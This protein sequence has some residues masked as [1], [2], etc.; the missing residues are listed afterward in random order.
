MTQAELLRHLVDALEALGA[1]Y[2]IGG[3]GERVTLKIVAKHADHWNCWG[4][5]RVLGR[6]GKIL[7]EH[8]A[9]L[10]RD[11]KSFKRSANMALLI[12]DNK[13]SGVFL[14][15]LRDEASRVI[16]GGEKQPA[17]SP[18][19]ATPSPV[20]VAPVQPPAPPPDR[21]AACTYNPGDFRIGTTEYTPD[22]FLQV[23]FDGSTARAVSSLKDRLNEARQLAENLG[24]SALGEV[25]RQ[26]RVLDY[27]NC[28]LKIEQ[29]SDGKK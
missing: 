16:L 27:F 28:R 12:T 9:A 29:A 25:Q 19:V 7:D 23:G 22:K 14:A 18:E 2:M 6:K 8:C 1:E 24:G 5:A 21:F 20:A 4:G 10:G 17:A 11:P 3:G 15:R 13:I 26:A